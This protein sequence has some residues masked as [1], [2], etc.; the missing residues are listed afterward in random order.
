VHFWLAQLYEAQGDPAKDSAQCGEY[1]KFVPIR[2]DHGHGE[3]SIVKLEEQLNKLDLAS[4]SQRRRSGISLP[5]PGDLQTD[6][7]VVKKA[8]LRDPF[9]DHHALKS[10]A[11]VHVPCIG[12]EM[13]NK[14]AP[15][16]RL[17]LYFTHAQ[18][19]VSTLIPI[20]AV[21]CATWAQD[22]DTEWGHTLPTAKLRRPSFGLVADKREAAE[23]SMWARMESGLPRRQD[24]IQR[25]PGH[26]ACFVSGQRIRSASQP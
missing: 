5:N 21:M 4:R 25:N 11:F 19:F 2:P 1:L 20:V 22:P 7:T 6:T 23:M 14:K 3:N 15:R 8:I 18:C 9:G 17:C 13:S 12:A 26:G 10:R 16:P 24:A